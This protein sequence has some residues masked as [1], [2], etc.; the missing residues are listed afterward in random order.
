M[1]TGEQWQV[2]GQLLMGCDDGAMSKLVILGPTRA[3]KD[4]HNIQDAQVHKWT[5]FGI[6]DLCSLLISNE[7]IFYYGMSFWNFMG[8]LY[9]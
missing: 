8:F 7:E 2:V 5:L 9:K 6:V 1:L 3:A 4:L